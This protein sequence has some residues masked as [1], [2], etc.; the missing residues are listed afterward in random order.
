VRRVLP[1][2]AVASLAFAPAP[3]PRPAKPD[4]SQDDLDKMQGDWVLESEMFPDNPKPLYCNGHMT[5][6]GTAMWRRMD[7]LVFRRQTI[8]VNAKSRPKAMDIS[9]DKLCVYE[10]SDDT[11]T[12]CYANQQ[13]PWGL[14]TS[15]QSIWREVWKRKKP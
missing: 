15:K 4:V 2:L 14:D 7:R 13:R 8:K 11:F 9:P 12:I 6:E 3:F 10:I 1:L 5:I